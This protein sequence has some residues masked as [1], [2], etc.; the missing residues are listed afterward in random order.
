MPASAEQARDIRIAVAGDDRRIEIGKRAPI[1]LALPQDG[2]PRQ[3]R[4]RAF[5]DQELEQFAVVV[6]GH[7]PFLVVVF[8]IERVVSAPGAAIDLG[9]GADYA[10][11]NMRPM[12]AAYCELDLPHD[13][14]AAAFAEPVELLVADRPEEVPGVLARVEALAADGCWLVGFVAYEAAAAFDSALVGHEPADG[15]PLAVFAA[16]RSR[17]SAR[18]R[19]DFMSGAWRDHHVVDRVR[20]APRVDQGRHRRRSLLS[21]QLHDATARAASLAIVRRCSMRCAPASRV[22]TASISISAAGKSVRCRRSCSSIG[23]LRRVA[24]HHG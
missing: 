12:S 18:P 17:A 7:A 22:P 1:V 21:G 16:F 14:L 5:E 20:I 2:D 4:L 6:A 9:H 19:G 8:D 10:P 23:V 3:P 13:G 15:L 11:G 24:Y